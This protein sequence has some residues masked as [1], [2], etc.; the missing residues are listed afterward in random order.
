MIINKQIKNI[1]SFGEFNQTSVSYV[2]IID[3]THLSMFTVPALKHLYVGPICTM[4]GGIFRRWLGSFVGAQPGSSRAAV[5]NW[6]PPLLSTWNPVCIP[7]GIEI[8]IMAILRNATVIVN[9]PYM[10]QYDMPDILSQC[11]D[12][13]QYRIDYYKYHQSYIRNHVEC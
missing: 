8:S 10:A 9:Q 5:L 7:V 6:I 1:C 3:L 2:L 4:S 13:L 11:H 12:I